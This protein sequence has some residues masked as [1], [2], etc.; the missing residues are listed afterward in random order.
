MKTGR[1]REREVKV[2]RGLEVGLDDIRQVRLREEQTRSTHL[3]ML[4]QFG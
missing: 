1:E 4:E 3:A 2:T